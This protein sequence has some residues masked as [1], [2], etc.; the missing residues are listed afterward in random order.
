[1]I[2]QENR[3]QRLSL[4]KQKCLHATFVILEKAKIDSFKSEENLT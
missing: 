2:A 1:M 4:N 3:R